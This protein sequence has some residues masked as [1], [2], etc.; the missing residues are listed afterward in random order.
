MQYMPNIGDRALFTRYYGYTLASAVAKIIASTD[1]K[2]KYNKII[3]AISGPGTVD[4]YYDGEIAP[5]ITVEEIIDKSTVIE[6]YNKLVAL[7]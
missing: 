7:K 1:N 3:G 4:S 6:I 2:Y 5:R